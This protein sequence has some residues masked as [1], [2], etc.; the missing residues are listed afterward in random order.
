MSRIA[1]P[2]LAAL[3]AIPAAAQASELPSAF[4]LRDIDGRSYI[5]PVRDQ[6]QCGSCYSF[7]SLAAAESAWNRAHNLYDD[8]AI[9]LSEAFMVWSLDPFYD[10]L[11]GCDGGY[12]QDA[13]DALVEYG[14]PLEADFPYTITDPGENLHWDAPRYTFEASYSIPTNDVE[15]T[16]RVLNSI[17]AVLVGVYVDIEEEVFYHYQGGIYED[18]YRVPEDT[19]LTASMNHAVSLVGWNDDPGD[20]GM[21]VWILRNSWGSEPWGEDGYMRIRYLSCGVNLSGQYLIVS[22]WAGPSTVLDNH[23][24]IDAVAWESGGTLNAHGV[25]LWGGAASRVANSGSICAEAAAQDELATARG[26]YLWGG[27]DGSMVNTGDIAGRASSQNNQAI[28]YA[29]CFQG[30]RVDN[31]G[32]LTAEA[33]GSPEMALAFGLWASNGTS[34]LRISNSGDIVARADQ[35]DSGTAYALWA[36]GRSITRVINTGVIS[37]EAARGAVGVAL[38]GGPA[39]LENSG[40]I[41]ANAEQESIGVFLNGGWVQLRNSGVISGGEYSILSWDGAENVGRCNVFLNLDTGSELNGP[42]SLDGSADYLMLT[43]SGSED[44]VFEGV[45][46]LAMIGNDWSLSGDSSFGEIHVVRGRLGV[47]GLIAGG[48]TVEADGVLGGDG[49]LTGDVTNSGTVAPGHSI[50]HLTI[51]GDFTQAADGTLEIEIGDGE[52]DR[53]TVTGTADLAGT[54]RIVPDGYTTGGSYTVLDA[55]S[56]IGAFDLLQIAAVLGV[57]RSDVASGSLSLDVTRNSYVSLAA[58][59]NRS[60][61]ASLDGTRAAAEG[62]LADLLDRLDL[63]LTTSELNADL[64]SLTPRLHG[65]ATVLALEGGQAGFESLRR[66][67]DRTDRSDSAD[68][69][70]EDEAVFWV[71]TPGSRNRYGSDGAYHGAR[72]NSYG[73][74]V[75][76]ERGVYERLTLGVAFAGTQ[77][78]YECD[79][80]ADEGE[81]TSLQARLYGV[82]SDPER[83]GGWRFGVAFGVGGAALE[84]DRSIAFAGRKAH[85]E[86]DGVLLDAMCHGGCDWTRGDWLF[87]PTFGLAWV[88]LHEEGFEESGADS[89]DLD[90]RSRNVDSFRGLL[91]WR[92]AREVNWSRAVWEPE[93]RAQWLHEFSPDT[94][95]LKATLA[96]GGEGFTTPGR[97][98]A[99]DSLV[100]GVGLGIRFSESTF[101]N[102]AYDCRRQS[103]DGAADHA[104]RLQAGVRF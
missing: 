25:D 35:S 99:R 71:E 30:G 10:G 74:T 96:G 8:Q 67:M 103:G 6:G 78:S 40:V 86:R 26:V 65:L 58:G 97:D 76:V 3:L 21:G 41:A 98:L 84:A 52:A 13:M 66:R 29:V 85:S 77:S 38:L 59:S 32:R 83:S 18:G 50:D 44:D 49:T 2:L 102:L 68:S 28:A 62:D 54:L 23:G 1:I 39:A 15:T 104:L 45:E 90:V 73:L 92:L 11:L 82:W 60:L 64:S 53:L 100:L 61:A 56:V 4:D 88:R 70:S 43:G 36:V 93:L 22:P 47:D 87:G 17:G 16:R 95:D 55:G 20:D 34:P 89:A 80:S 57:E 75:G 81:N 69:E 94:G 46:H 14:V 5:G 72:E 48:A 37:A 27:S 19:D 63:A 51:D 9:D 79:R 12:L 91:G 7:G 101:A 33:E 31:R 42:V 24:V